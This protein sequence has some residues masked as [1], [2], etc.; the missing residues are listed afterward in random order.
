MTE[1]SEKKVTPD[2]ELFDRVLSNIVERKE[3][4][5]K[6]LI[7]SIPW[8]F[9]RFSK[10]V[11]GLEKKKIYQVTAGPKCGKSK[12][13]NN[14]FLYNAYD[15]LAKNNLPINLRVKYYCLEESKE[16]LISQFMSFTLFV[17]TMGQMVVSPAKLMSTEKELPQEVLDELKIHEAYILGF[18]QRVEYIED[19]HHPF[20][21]YKDL[22]D[23]AKL[24]GTQTKKVQTWN[25]KEV[26][27]LYIPNDPEEIVIA[28]IDHVSLLQPKRGHGKAD[29]INELSNFMV[30]LRNKYSY[31][32]ILVQQQA[33]VQSSMEGIKFN[34]G[35]PTIA[36]LGDSKLTSRDIDISFGLYSPFE[37]KVKEYEGYDITFYRDN[38]RFVNVLTSR[39]GG[40]GVKVPLYFNGATNFF[41]ELPKPGTP[42]EAKKKLII[43]QIRNNEL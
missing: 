27:D 16:A 4:I 29:A 38:I 25:K 12:L 6:G 15:F 21:I 31:S 26:D 24:N 32:A 43:T 35:E 36:N 5:N 30:Q 28:V 39:H 13:T 41:S 17:K 11:I 7:N 18:I 33:L 20:G 19:I 1:I 40:A 37:N 9:E 14:M 22:L 10:H 2:K 42:E 8:G 34:Q 23:Y 3:R